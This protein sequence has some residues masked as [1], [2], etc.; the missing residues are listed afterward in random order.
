MIMRNSS[1]G[2]T[3]STETACHSLMSCVTVKHATT[4]D[5]ILYITTYMHIFYTVYFIHGY[6]LRIGRF[7]NA[8]TYLEH[9]HLTTSCMSVEAM[10]T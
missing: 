5:R 3:I 9:R 8:E 1:R 4:T 7:G 10:P 2:R 6:L